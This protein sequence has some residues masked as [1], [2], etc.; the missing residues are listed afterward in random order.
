MQSNIVYYQ[1]SKYRYLQNLHM[2]LDQIG[3]AHV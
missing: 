1:I 2:V 3:R